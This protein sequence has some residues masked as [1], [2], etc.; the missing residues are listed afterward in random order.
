MK[1]Y[2][3]AVPDLGAADFKILWI[4]DYHDGI[5]CGMLEYRNE[6][7]RYEII[8]DFM[9]NELPRVYAVIQLTEEQIKEETNWNRLFQKY[10]GNHNNYDTDEPLKQQPAARHHLFYDE[11]KK[12]QTPNYNLNLVKAWFTQYQL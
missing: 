7:F 6:K 5:L 10:V 8:T 1:K 12:R 2:K 4:D 9:E 3:N 11:Y